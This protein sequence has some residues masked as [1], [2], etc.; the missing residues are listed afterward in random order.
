MS[1]ANPKFSLLQST[2]FELL[3]VGIEKK[4]KM[5]RKTVVSNSLNLS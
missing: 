5:R 3:G 4:R 1:Y 2:P